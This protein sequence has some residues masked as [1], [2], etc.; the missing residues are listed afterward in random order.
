MATIAASVKPIISISL[1]VFLKL[2]KS[3][4]MMWQ[5]SAMARRA[6]MLLAILNAIK[7][8]NPFIW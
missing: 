8:F 4:D 6:R 2:S 7:D 3:E 5:I 1:I